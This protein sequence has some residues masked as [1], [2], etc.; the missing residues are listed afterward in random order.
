MKAAPAKFAR[1]AAGLSSAKLRK[2]PAPGKWSI[3]EILGHLLDTEVIYA[4]RYRM[5]MGDSGG[6]I[7]G[8]DQEKMVR[9]MAWSRKRWSVKRI[10]EH[11]AALRRSTLFVL[12]NVPRPYRERYGLH[13]ERGK[14]TVRRTQEMIAGHDLNHLA[15]MKAIRKKYGW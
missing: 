3:Q 10:L 5:M 9:E 11:I 12:E 8:Y 15:Q 6:P 14:E 7:Q 13:S 1:A 4:Y 2:R